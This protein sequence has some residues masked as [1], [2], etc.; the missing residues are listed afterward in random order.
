[1]LNYGIFCFN[2]YGIPSPIASEPFIIRSLLQESVN[3][4]DNKDDKV[5]ESIT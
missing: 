1:M 4:L 2:Q 5:R 3:I